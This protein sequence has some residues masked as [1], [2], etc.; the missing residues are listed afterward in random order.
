[1]SPKID[2]H[3]EPPPNRLPLVAFLLLMVAFCCHAWSNGDGL[4]LDNAAEK[5]RWWSGAK[6]Q[7]WVNK[8]Q[9]LNLWK[10]V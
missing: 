5:Q 1:M 2:C 9:K 4:V 3:V 10:T 6:D 8:L 7:I